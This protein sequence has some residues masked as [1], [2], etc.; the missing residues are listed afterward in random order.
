[1][2]AGGT[3]TFTI[4]L[5][6]QPTANV[7]IPVATNDASEGL[8]S[9]AN[10]TFTTSNWNVAKTVVV[11]GA[12]DAVDDGDVAYGITL[13]AATSSDP[14][15]AAMDPADVALTNVD[16]DTAGII[17][18]PVAGLSTTEAGGTA[19]FTVALASQP[20]AGVTIPVSSSDPSEGTASVAS[21]TFT[22]G[23]WNVAQT[24]TVTGVDDAVLDGDVGFGVL[25]GLPATADTLYA[26][27]DPAD[28]AVT[29][30]DNDVTG[31]TVTPVAGLSTTEAGGTASFTVVL[32][33][34]PA[35]DV[36]IPVAS[37]DPSEGVP[38]ASSLTFTAANWNA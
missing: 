24:V 32:A 33:S 4:V 27:I 36:V 1:T 10:V 31:V 13:G 9:V 17:V 23:N 38:S 12:D 22:P 6:S 16:N 34:Q 3:A 21:L 5:R 19:S 15:Y 20:T 37:S 7:V 2:E 14:R 35:A 8:A 28:V 26:A 18:T 11:T 29:D 30:I 25:L